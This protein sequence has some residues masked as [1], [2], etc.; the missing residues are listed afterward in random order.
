MSARF[1][2]LD[3]R[4]TALGEISLRR[5]RDPVSRQDVLEVKLGEEFLMSSMFTVAE[6]ELARLALSESPAE[7]LDVVVGGL[8]LGYTA[9]TALESS[10]VASM[11]VVEALGEVIEWHQQGLIPAGEDLTAD[12]RCQYVHSNFFTMA[13]SPSGFDPESPG[14]RFHAI[15]LDVDHSPRHVLHPENASFYEPAGMKQLAAHLHP[16]GIFA[17]WS[18]DPPDEEYMNSLRQVFDGVKAEVVRFPNPLQDKEATNTVYLARKP[19]S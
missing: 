9:Q 17:L 6:V 19:S 16:G 8:G 10:R 4:D 11:L 15:M 14:R 3:W 1:E 7:R 2:E 12:P 18:N 5:R 13:A